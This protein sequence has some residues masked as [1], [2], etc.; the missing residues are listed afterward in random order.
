[1]TEIPFAM[2]IEDNPEQSEIFTK[3][4]QLAGFEVEAI[5]DGQAAMDRLAVTIPQVV[6]LDLHLPHVSGDKIL[7]QIRSDERLSMTRVILATANPHMADSLR[8]DS[9]LVL[10]KPISFTQLKSL[11]ERLRP[12]N[13][14]IGCNCS[15]P[16]KKP[17]APAAVPGGGIPN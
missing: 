9:D 5:L 2:I 16:P 14:G 1:M 6:V 10:I 3:A 11:A 12:V 17:V 8:D 15:S 4:L 7:T 13:N